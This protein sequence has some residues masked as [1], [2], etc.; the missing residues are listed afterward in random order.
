MRIEGIVKLLDALLPVDDC[1][2]IA[3]LLASG[4][5]TEFPLRERLPIVLAYWTAT[6]DAD[7]ELILHNDLYARDRKLLAA[8]QRNSY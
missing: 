3:R 1:A 4:K 7:G 2:E 8:L 6:V 5:T